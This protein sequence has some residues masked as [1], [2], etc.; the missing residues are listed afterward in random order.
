MM[1]VGISKSTV[2]YPVNALE[3]DNMNMLSCYMQLRKHSRPL[4]QHKLY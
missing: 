1:A 3:D 4:V 2:G